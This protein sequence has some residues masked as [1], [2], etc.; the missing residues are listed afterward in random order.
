MRRLALAALALALLGA[1]AQ[2]KT[3]GLVFGV[4]AYPNFPADKQLRAPAADVG[5]I[6]RAFSTRGLK[7]ED[8]VV[9]ADGVEGARAAPTRAAILGELDRLGEEA[10]RGDLVVIYGSGHGSRQPS[11]AARKSDGLDQLFLPSDAAFG[12]GAKPFR[13]AIV[14]TEFGDRIDRIR[15]K[16]ADVWFILDACFSGAASRAAF[17]T[18]RDKSVEPNAGAVAFA[19]ALDPDKATPLAERAPLPDGAGKLVAFYASQPNETAREVALPASA[20]LAKRAWGSIFTLALAQALER[21]KGLTYRQTLV[22]AGRILR[23]DAGF[24]SRQ[25]PSFEGDGLDAPTPGARAAEGALWRVVGGTLRAGR[26]EGVDPGAILALYADVDAPPQ[27]P[28]VFARVAEAE[29]L[30]ARLVAVRKG[31]DPRAGDCRDDPSASALAKAA[32]ARLARP[33]PA[34]RLTL[35]P[36]A[37]FPGAAEPAYVAAARVALDALTSGP[38]GERV[39]IDAAAPDL[40]LWATRDGVRFAPAGEDPT[41]V[42]S[43]PLVPAA[44]FADPAQALS[45]AVARARQTLALRRI[46]ADAPGSG[47]LSASLEARRFPRDASGKCAFRSEGAALPEGEPLDICDKMIATFENQGR[48]AVLPAIFFVDDGWNLIA[49]RPACPVGL[50]V[51]DRLEPGRR[52]SFEI[53]YAPRSISPGLAP[54]TANAVLAVAAPFRAGESDLPNLC[55]LAAYNDGA[56]ATRGDDDDLDALTGGGRRG[57]ARLPLEATAMSFASWRVRQPVKR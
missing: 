1:G 38:L 25:T 9:L 4:S 8:F 24:Q 15:M 56:G 47:A 11:P 42:E 27:T 20:P 6:L 33:A 41:D 29:A 26:L 10:G 23:A 12:E 36:L 7:R 45:R 55:G 57:G 50:S 37:V 34:A 32:Y 54:L 28:L 44:A 35:S 21:G 18:A 14:S 49:R 30:Q 53:P 13:E 16:G 43:G 48:E 19:S 51:A 46:A 3:R 31:C 39:A 5:R 22:E 2:A 17:E 52:L 40:R